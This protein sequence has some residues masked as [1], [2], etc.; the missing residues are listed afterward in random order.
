LRAVSLNQMVKSISSKK[1]LVIPKESENP[2]TSIIRT[3]AHLRLCQ[4]FC[5]S[6]HRAVSSVTV[7]E[8]PVADVS[9]ATHALFCSQHH[10]QVTPGDREGSSWLPRQRLQAHRFRSQLGASLA[11]V[12]F[13]QTSP[14]ISRLAS[15]RPY[16]FSSDVLFRQPTIR[17][18]RL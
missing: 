1:T 18:S 12:V 11:L 17:A 9:F 5:L 4:C 3:L 13:T 2:S 6:S 10:C 7:I 14:H 8:P 16:M 15:S